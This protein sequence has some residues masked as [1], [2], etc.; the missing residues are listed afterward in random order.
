MKKTFYVQQ[1]IGKAKY[2]VNFHDGVNKCRDGSPFF[3]IRICKNKKELNEVTTE[4]ASN[5][6]QSSQGLPAY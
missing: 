3:D 2:V 6:Y 4:L 1:N 5:G